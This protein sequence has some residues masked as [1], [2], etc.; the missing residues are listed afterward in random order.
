MARRRKDWNVSLAADLS[1]R[2]AG[3]TVRYFAPA[4]S[5]PTYL[6]FV[7]SWRPPTPLFGTVQRRGF[8]RDHQTAG[9]SAKREQ[10]RESPQK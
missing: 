6:P 10:R 8:A 1:I 2:H 5:G 9:Q 3:A 4:K 7:A